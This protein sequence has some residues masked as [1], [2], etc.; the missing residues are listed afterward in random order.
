MKIQTGE[1]ITLSNNKEYICFSTLSD[2]GTDYVYLMSNFK[3][4]EIRFGIQKEI[5]GEVEVT[6]INNQEQKQKVLKLF[7]EHNANNIPQ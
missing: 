1:V 4:L 5:D 6:I 3:P 2:D 7:Q